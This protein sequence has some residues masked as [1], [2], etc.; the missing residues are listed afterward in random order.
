LNITKTNSLSFYNEQGIL[1]LNAKQFDTGRMFVFHIMHNDVPFDLS[2]CAAYL[3]IAKAD[4]TQFQGH[5]CCTIEGSKVIIKT[6]IGNGSQILT[7]AGTNACELHLEDSDGTSLTTWTFHIVVEPRVHDGSH[8]SSIDSYDVL[9]NMINMEKERIANEEQRK[10][11]EANR[12]TVFE[13]K[14]E[15]TN[16]V[17]TDCHL[18]IDAANQK[19]SSFDAEINEI[20]DG[21]TDE[22]QSYADSAKESETNAAN[23]ASSAADSAATALQKAGDAAASAVLS[24]SYA[25]GGTQSRAG[26]DVDNAKYYSEKSQETLQKLQETTVTSIKGN[27]ESAYR[28]GDVNITP[29]NIGLGNVNNTSD[30]NKPVSNAQRTAIDAK[31]SKSGDTMTGPLNFANAIWNVVGDD[32]AIGD[33]NVA[34]TLCLKG[35]NGYPGIRLMDSAENVVGEVVHTGAFSSLRKYTID[36][37]GQSSSNFYFIEFSGAALNMAIDCEIRSNLRLSGEPF[38]C[39]YVKFQYV[40]GGWSDVPSHLEILNH[41]THDS[42]EICIMSIV[43]GYK[44]GHAGIYV[45]GDNRYDILCNYQPVLHISGVTLYDEYF[46][47][48]NTTCYY[49]G[50]D[51][52]GID[53]NFNENRTNFSLLN[54]EIRAPLFNG[55]ASSIRDC[56][57]GRTLTFNYSADGL[58]DPT[59][60]AAWN[61]NEL[62][63]VAASKY[64]GGGSGDIYR[65]SYRHNFTD[66][67]RDYPDNS[68]DYDCIQFN[69][70]VMLLVG[71][72]YGHQSVSQ[73][74]TFPISFVNNK[75]VVVSSNIP[76]EYAHA[77]V[78][79]H[80]YITERHTGSSLGSVKYIDVY[81]VSGYMRLTRTSGCYISQTYDEWGNKSLSFIAMGRWK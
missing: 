19:I 63:G 45:R 26:E 28:T 27:A 17:I 61:G 36:L 57:D 15:E 37:S 50:F 52:A 65:Y 41:S 77:K 38:N 14:I 68:F 39:N 55:P 59:W 54:T 34:G 46:P 67:N 69:N 48:G 25:V 9:D 31:V 81:R 72:L 10:E 22:A 2:G 75:Y 29:D 8:M 6:N 4:G 5:E 3:R 64:K 79:D 43:R 60:L 33:M 18:V 30:E 7:A 80:K 16:A 73:T 71:F 51:G 74:I 1:T 47:S 21:I 11:N 42:S 24:Q 78:F 23:A 49:T 70:G 35:L 66:E 58:D 56:G 40:S 44:S 12:N 13:Q 32:V 53:V 76:I 20:V 62:R